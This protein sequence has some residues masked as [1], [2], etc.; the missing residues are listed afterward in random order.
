MQ[1]SRGALP[2]IPAAKH[3]GP[4]EGNPPA[5]VDRP[6]CREQHRRQGPPEPSTN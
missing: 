3:L 4:L 5:Q 2:F 6:P 1:L